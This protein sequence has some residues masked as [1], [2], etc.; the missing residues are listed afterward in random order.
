MKTAAAAMKTA[1]T[2]A[3][4]WALLG[5]LLLWIAVSL[6]PDP[7]AGI[8]SSAASPREFSAERALVPVSAIAQAPHPI[9]SAEHARVRDYVEDQFRRLGVEPAIQTGTGEY[10]RGS[11][12]LSGHVE[13]IVARLPGGANTRSVML[14]AHYDST[15][16]GPGASDDAHGVA[17][18]LETLRALRSGPP[19]RND[20]IFLVTDGEERGLLGAD[21]FMRE[22]PWRQEP[23]VVLN[24]EARG[25]SGPSY[26][27]ETSAGNAWLIDA[28]RSAVP[29]ANAPSVSYEIYKRMPNDTDFTVFKH[30]GLQG[31]NFAFIGHPEFYHRPQDDVAHLD[32]R[33][34]Q[35]DGN[36]ALALTRIFG[37][38][39]LR[40]RRSDNAVY[41]PTLLTPLIV[42][43]ESWAKPLA[44]ILM[45]ALA[46]A[47]ALGRRRGRWIAIVLAPLAALDI[48][49][50][51]AAPGASY[52]L[53]WPLAASVIAF[54][55]LLTAPA[56]LAI[57][58]R[59]AVLAVLP[60]AVL[61]LLMPFALSI[62]VALGPRGVPVV[63][64]TV[65]VML[66]FLAPQIV[67]V[68][69]PN[70][71]ESS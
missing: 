34:L 55:I 18:L 64:A 71:A 68:C 59:I 40:E 39:D 42:Y 1:A 14:A 27:F 67:L 22:H 15:P 13:N 8:V 2:P 70:T 24:F 28:L 43:P 47:T 29:R 48:W 61:L 10:S 46:I 37:N 17:V 31:M 69:R 3:A 44:W 36:Y 23:G 62:V 63:A 35:E 54:A 49:L 9:L 25:T 60:A 6:A 50:A 38:Q 52:L 12:H 56:R 45:F 5:A 30:H 16:R 51:G 58:W 4:R 32:R 41:F 65:L 53:E 7:R 20:V 21:V 26:M 66:A 19:L 33:S 57:G 11:F